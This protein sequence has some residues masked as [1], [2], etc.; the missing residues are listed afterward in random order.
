VKTAGKLTGYG[1]NAR[2]ALL[3]P[4]KDPAEVTAEVVRKSIRLAVPYSRALEI[5]VKMRN[6]YR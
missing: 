3:P 2:V 6:P 1:F 5:R 4:G